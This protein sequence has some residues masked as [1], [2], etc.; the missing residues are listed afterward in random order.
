MLRR[1]S[2]I[3]LLHSERAR[4]EGKTNQLSI[5]L[6]ILKNH[7]EMLVALSADGSL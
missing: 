4:R 2:A 7:F 5:E 6:T 1:G 3:S